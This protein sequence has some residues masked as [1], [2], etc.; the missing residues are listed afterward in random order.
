MKKTLVAVAATLMSVCSMAL[1]IQIKADIDADTLY[2]KIGKDTYQK[3]Y[4]L[5]SGEARVIVS[6]D[7]QIM[8]NQA[9]AVNE[10]EDSSGIKLIKV[11]GKKSVRIVDQEVSDDGYQSN[12]DA[13]VSAKVKKR[14]G[15][16]LK[17]ISIDKNQLLALYKAE[18]ERSGI[19]QLRSLNID[20]E[21]LKLSTSIE[22]S[23]M[24]C[25][26]SDDTLNCFENVEMTI[27]AS[28]E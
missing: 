22:L 9:Q 18:L 8:V 6:Q 21:E 23:G 14:F 28:D 24:E 19:N 17:S 11:L 12:I 27:T 4:S 15:G 20:T 13:E 25:K 2:K 3:S 16:S 26:A 7:G 10:R 1:T 5:M